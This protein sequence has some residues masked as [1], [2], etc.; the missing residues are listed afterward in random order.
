MRNHMSLNILLY[1]WSI[2]IKMESRAA[3]VAQQ[4]GAIFIPGHDPG[5]P[6]SS[7]ASGSLHGAC[8][9]LCLCLSKMN[10]SLMI[11]NTREGDRTWETPNS[12]KWTRGSGKGGG[13]VRV[14]GWRALR[15]ALDR[16]CTGCYAI[17][18]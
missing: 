9:S 11:E 6:G 15:G 17:C 14:T 8:F 18:W 12:G 7:S 2:F 3:L 4:F 5:D 10:K 1:T 13:A 16:M